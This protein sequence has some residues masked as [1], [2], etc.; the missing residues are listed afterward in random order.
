[1]W[2]TTS[3][4]T[5][6][7]RLVL[8]PELF[9]YPGCTDAIACNFNPDAE[10]D[11]GSCEYESCAGCMEVEACNFDPSATISDAGLCTYPG[12][13][14]PSA[15]N[16]EASAGCIG[17]CIYLTYDCASI[18]DGAW[19]DE[20]MGLFPDWQEA[21]H[22]IPWEGEWVFNVPGTIIEPGSGVPYG[23]HH[24]DWVNMEG[25]PGWATAMSLDEGEV[26]E[27]S[28][29]LCI[30]AFGTPTTPGTHE[31]TA[32]GEVFISIFGQPF[33]IGEQ[34]FPAWLEVEENP[35]PIPGCTYATAQNFLAFATL[36]DGSC[37]FAGCTDPEADNFNPLA[38]IEDG[39]CGEGC[40]TASD[41]SCQ[42]DNDGDGLISVSDLL[43]LLGEFGSV[44]E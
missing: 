35:N 11:N 38:T 34:S 10:E 6:A 27:A 40:D 1:M 42:A 29:Q 20:A 25:V 9:T 19:S 22:G 18:G 5:P 26:V 43:I 44:C 4:F 31:V 7:I 8:S 2:F 15:A 16:Y 12:C 24:V 37:E 21:V 39:S 14:D 28:T 33:S 30:P 17:E 13:D 36:D 3:P 23:V 32:I 41:A